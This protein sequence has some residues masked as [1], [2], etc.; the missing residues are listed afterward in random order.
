LPF[1]RQQAGRFG[2]APEPKAGTISVKLKITVS[3]SAIVRRISKKQY[4]ARQ[5]REFVLAQIP[6]LM[7]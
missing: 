4:S 6:H 1:L 2:S 3:A 5:T 7:V